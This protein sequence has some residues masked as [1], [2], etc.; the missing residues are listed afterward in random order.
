MSIF[1]MGVVLAP[2]LGPILG[3]WLTDNYGWPWIFYINVPVSI[4]AIVMVNAFVKDPPICDAASPV[5]TGSG[6]RC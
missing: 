3:G 1:G 4:V 5:S 6:W 2:A